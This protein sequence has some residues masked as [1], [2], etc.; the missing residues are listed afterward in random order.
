M[1]LEKQIIYSIN[2]IKLIIGH[3]YKIITKFRTIEGVLIE[4]DDVWS[5]IIIDDI[6]I[7]VN[8]IESIEKIIWI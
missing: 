1:F 5:V 8:F 7:A 2:T 3:R 4:I 6:K